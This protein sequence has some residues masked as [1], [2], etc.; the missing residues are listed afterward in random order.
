MAKTTKRP[1]RLDTRSMD[2]FDKIQ[3]YYYEKKGKIVLTDNVEQIRQ[4]MRLCYEDLC[5][6]ETKVSVVEKY[7]TE[8]GVSDV[9]IYHYIKMAEQ[10]FPSML[11]TPKEADR[12]YLKRLYQKGIKAAEIAEE[13]DRICYF[14]LRL[15]KLL[16]LQDHDTVP[17]DWSTIQ[18]APIIINTDPD[19]LKQQAR[20]IMD[21][22]A[23]DAEW[24]EA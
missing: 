5:N 11:D 3:A 16:G 2:A 10:L 7:S 9:T 21:K 17:V 24:H 20:A 22:Y 1:M 15:E 18:I 14:G 12:A 23:E 6:F 8:W 4:R 13:W 19:T